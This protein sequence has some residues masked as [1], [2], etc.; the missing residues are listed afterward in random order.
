M[1]DTY[2]G[3]P[4]DTVFDP[5]ALVILVLAVFAA[6]AMHKVFRGDSEG[7]PGLVIGVLFLLYSLMTKF[8]VTLLGVAV[9][10]GIAVFF[11]PRVQIALGSLP[12]ARHPVEDDQ[13]GDAAE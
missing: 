11:S 4:A 5:A 1:G 6:H 9:Y 3:G 10:V 13:P 8:G 2:N 7:G 12:R